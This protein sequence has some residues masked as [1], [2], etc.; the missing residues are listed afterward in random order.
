M[1]LLAKDT[2]KATIL[3][4]EDD[5]ETRR[6]IT[7]LVSGKF[8]DISVISAENGRTGLEYFRT[9]HPDIVVT[10]VRMPV[11]DGIRMAR[12]IKNLSKDTRIIVTTA[13]NDISHILE[14]IEIGVSHYVLKPIDHDKLL[15]TIHC[16]LK[17]I[18]QERQV[19]EQLEFFRRLSQAVDHGA[20][21][22]M[23]TD[24]RGEIVFVN[25]GFTR[26]TGYISTE[27]LGKGTWLLKSGETPPE[28][29]RRLWETIG[30]GEEWW[31]ELRNRKKNGE[32]FWVSESISPITDATGKI[33]HFLSRMED[34]TEKKQKLESILHLAYYDSLTSLP[35]QHF[36]HELLHN[37]LAQAQRYERMLAVLFLDLDRF[38]NIN[39]TLGHSVGDQLLK[40]VAQRLKDCCSREGDTVGRR[41]GDEFIILLPELKD[42]N[43]PV[44]VAQRIINAF[45]RTFIL[46]EHE[47]SISTSIGISIFPHDG[48][49]PE[50]LIKK[51]DMA[52]YRAKEGGRNRYHLYTPTTDTQVF[53][54]LALENSL[55]KAF[56]RDEFLLHYQPKLNIATGRVIS[57]EALVRWR[58][59]EMGLVMPTQFI[60]LAEETGLIAPLGEWVLRAAC[61]QNKAWQDAGYPSMRIAVNIS[62]KQFQ[63]HNLA[64][65]VERALSDARLNA[66]C[67][68]L[69]ITENVMLRNED[70]VAKTL[71]RLSDLGVHISIDDFGT[72][73]STFSY[74]RRIPID[75]LKIDQSFINDIC[76]N[77]NDEAITT[78]VIDMAQSLNLNVVAEGVETEEQRKLLES[79]NCSEMQGYYFSRPL[80]ADEFG[81]YLD[82]LEGNCGERL[83]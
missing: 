44:R 37:A 68:E 1:Q 22:I 80:P 2:C 48:G 81:K 7:L 20:I 32:L 29:Y 11:M 3:Y 40:A 57:V 24:T 10:D 52:M 72:G 67:L 65:I 15:D 75:S 64:E 6:L 56:E 19:R 71:C 70:A 21:S 51:A 50:A 82:N 45:S 63:L 12:E 8:P 14:A 60:P 4:V 35:N 83:P 9:H 76:S 74:I 26:L 34:I 58:H 38:K 18:S 33:T 16:C 61:V 23:M 53:E 17:G 62:P 30:A 31:G 77:L 55:R 41:G 46:P 42:V 43:G 25:P 66:D 78:A 5:G 13:V 28:E 27:V 79:L 49:D 69:E 54:R 36:F 73:Y 39:D 59:P 47:L